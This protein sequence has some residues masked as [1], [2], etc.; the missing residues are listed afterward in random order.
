[1]LV[2]VP[3]VLVQN[4]VQVTTAENEDPVQALRPYRS[5]PAFRVGIGSRRT[6]GGFDDPDALGGEHLVE[7]G[8]ELGIPVPDQERE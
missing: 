7:A 6:N 3:D 4:P 2:V 1:M 8:R 5:H